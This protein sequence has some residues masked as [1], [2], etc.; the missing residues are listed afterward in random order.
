MDQFFESAVVTLKCFGRLP[1]M[2]V[3]HGSHDQFVSDLSQT[4]DEHPE[5]VYAK[6]TG[7]TLQLIKGSTLLMIAISNNCST[8]TSMLIKRGADLRA[9][10]EEG[11]TPLYH[12]VK[13]KPYFPTY[14]SNLRHLF[15][16]G[17]ALD[18]RA[19]QL[20]RNTCRV[21]DCVFVVNQII[22]M[23]L[24]CNWSRRWPFL[25]VLCG[26]GF[27]KE[28]AVSPRNKV[29]FVFCNRD[30]CEWIMSFI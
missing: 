27:Q 8:L 5:Y 25:H 24:D 26:C 14:R 7:S 6:Y 19:L 2:R 11:N 9:R 13:V 17:M 28:H 1:G 4:L 29:D 10:D 3:H 21:Y 18:E 22:K 20:L 15:L 30:L 16:A 23:S 12:A